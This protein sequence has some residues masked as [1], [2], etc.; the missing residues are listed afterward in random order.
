MGFRISEGIIHFDTAPWLVFLML[1]LVVVWL[2]LVSTFFVAIRK[3]DPQGYVSMGKPTFLAPGSFL[4]V[5]SYIYRRAHTKAGHA[6][7]SALCD[8]MCLWL[9]LTVILWCAY[10]FWGLGGPPVDL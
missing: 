6:G 10:Y 9:P 7:F 2:V 1:L 5:M 8:V 3:C 4:V